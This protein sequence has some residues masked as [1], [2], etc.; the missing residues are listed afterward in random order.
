MHDDDKT[1]RAFEK[2]LHVR[3]KSF[4]KKIK[5][6]KTFTRGYISKS[7]WQIRDQIAFIRAKQQFRNYKTC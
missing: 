7:F 4:Q 6:M 1:C 5:I 3:K 2:S